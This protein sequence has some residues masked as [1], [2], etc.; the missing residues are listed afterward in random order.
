MEKSDFEFYDRQLEKAKEIIK[1][2]IQIGDIDL[3][4]NKYKKQ[5]NS[6]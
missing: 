1:D 2:F 3:V 4:I 5:E 6:S